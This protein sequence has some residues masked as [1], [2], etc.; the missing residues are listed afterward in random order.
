METYK[1]RTV[2]KRNHKIEIDNLP[3]DDG[4][5][6]NVIVTKV[7]KGSDKNYE[8]RGTFLK[9]DNPFDSAAEDEWEVLK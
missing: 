7:E 3:F 6:V 8:L 9:Y 5:D 4:E 2:I 1:I